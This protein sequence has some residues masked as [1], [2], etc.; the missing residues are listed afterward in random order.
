[1][2]CTAI[3]W[4]GWTKLVVVRGALDAEEYVTMLGNHLEPFITELHP[5]NCL[6]QQDG[7]FAYKVKL[8]W[9]YFMKARNADIEWRARY[10][11]LNF[12]ENA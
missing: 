6:F 11:S 7:A 3:F 12:I 9:E 5:Q 4:N 2:V 8:M 1:M 10:S